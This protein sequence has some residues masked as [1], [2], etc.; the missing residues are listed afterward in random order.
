MFAYTNKG[1][2][3]VGD[4]VV[5]ELHKLGVKREDSLITIMQVSEVKKVNDSPLNSNLDEIEF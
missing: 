1:E 5:L 3:K 2:L 4:R